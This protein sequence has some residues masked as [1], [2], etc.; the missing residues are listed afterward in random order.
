MIVRL[1]GRSFRSQP[2]KC[3]EMARIEISPAILF[4][5]ELDKSFAALQALLIRME[6]HQ[7]AF[8]VLS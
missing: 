4:I 5:D 7:A 3:T 6:A 8:S 2:E 1:Y